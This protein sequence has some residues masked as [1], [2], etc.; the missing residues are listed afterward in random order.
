MKSFL[1]SGQLM[2]GINY[3]AS[4]TSIRMWEEFHPGVIDADFEKLASK[5][6][7]MLRVFPLWPVFQPLKAIYNNEGIYEFRFGEEPLPDTEA[8]RAGVSEEA[9]R[10]FEILCDLAEKHGLSLLVGLITGHMS[11]RYFAPEPFQAR[12][13][14][15][16]PTL[17]KWELRFV[18]YFV[19][20]FCTRKAIAAWDLGNEC[21]GFFGRSDFGNPD[22]AYVWASALA[23]AIRSV[24]GV[25]PVVS[26]FGMNGIANGALPQTE[27]DEIVD[28]NT[29]HPYNIFQTKNDPL[30]SM[31]P[32]LDG[33]VRAKISEGVSGIPAFIQEVGAIGYL[34]CS[35]ATEAMFYRA[36]LWSAYAHDCGGVMWWCAFDQGMQ[37]YAPYD[38]N[39]I[40]SQYGFFRAD[41]SAKPVAEENVTFR[42]RI[43]VLPFASLPPAVID[44]VCVIPRMEGKSMLPVL[45]NVFCLAK[46]ANLDLSFSYFDAP[47]PDAPLYILPDMEGT[48]AISRHR[49]MPLLEKVKAGATLYISIGSGFFR[50]IPELTGC[51]FAYRESGGTE[52]V[53]VGDRKMRV[54]SDFRYCPECTGGAEVL[55]TA[56]DGRGVLFRHA[57]GEGY[58][59]FATLSVEKSLTE[60]G[61]AMREGACAAWY[62]AAMKTVKSAKI[63]DGDHPSVRFT[64]HIASGTRRYAIAINY[65][66]RAVSTSVSISPEWE[67]ATAYGA[68]LDGKLLALPPCDAA[69]LILERK[70]K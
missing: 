24:D 8:G 22:A 4:D 19:R 9:C 69:V 55:A 10:N 46:Q 56:E 39:N 11:F 51:A 12:S 18:T 68:E 25:H 49:L 48:R 37:T 64:E 45:R 41:G 30:T 62:R 13:P 58:I 21:E 38:W 6:I 42:N 33:I 54:K 44:G 28:V 57:Y 5:G 7:T 65:S 32:I 66:D 17:V 23:N 26:G 59:C 29:V 34:V 35:E 3:W 14:I 60:D 63:L 16:D 40:G 70:E 43:A 52:I 31:R 2:T 27:I 47:L 61:R 20:R 36:L 1:S 50:M 15:T 53:A 67:I